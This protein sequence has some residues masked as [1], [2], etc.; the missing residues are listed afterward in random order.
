MCENGAQK[1]CNVIETNGRFG[2]FLALCFT[3]ARIIVAV[4]IGNLIL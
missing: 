1:H 3:A 4:R 2:L